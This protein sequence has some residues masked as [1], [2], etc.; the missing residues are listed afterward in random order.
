MTTASIAYP[1]GSAQLRN[2]YLKYVSQIVDARHPIAIAT[3]D[4]DIIEALCTEHD[5]AL[6]ADHV[7]FEMLLGL[8]TEQLDALSAAGFTTREYVLFGTEWW[9][10]VLNRIA[11]EPERIYTALIDAAG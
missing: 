10:Y 1:R 6:K 5:S 3:H 7:E 11:E 2:A 9:L 8:G 4:R